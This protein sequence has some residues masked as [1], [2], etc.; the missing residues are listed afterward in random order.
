MAMQ[1]LGVDQLTAALVGM[2]LIAGFRIAA[3]VWKI[4]LPVFL[5]VDEG[6]K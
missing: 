5:V 3:I 6:S 4:R 2:A 1:A